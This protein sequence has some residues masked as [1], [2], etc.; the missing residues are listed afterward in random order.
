MVVNALIAASDRH[1]T[2]AVLLPTLQDPRNLPDARSPATTTLLYRPRPVL[3]WRSGRRRR[4]S[5]VAPRGRIRGFDW[6]A[7]EEEEAAAA[8]AAAE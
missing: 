2:R 3:P 7:R 8:A 6:P 4:Q 1:N 5:P